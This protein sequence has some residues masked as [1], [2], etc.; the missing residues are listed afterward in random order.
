MRQIDKSEQDRAKTIAMY[1]SAWGLTAR[2][3]PE[4]GS[5]S[6]FVPN[7]F[8]IYALPALTL[9]NVRMRQAPK[10]AFGLRPCLC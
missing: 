6:D 1:D 2:W 7:I 10:F 4:F 5:I 9:D 8:Y 3:A